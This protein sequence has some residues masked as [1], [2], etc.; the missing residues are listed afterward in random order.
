MGN[1]SFNQYKKDPNTFAMPSEFAKF[2]PGMYVDISY[3][4]GRVINIKSIFMT[5]YYRAIDS[6]GKI[7]TLAYTYMGVTPEVYSIN[8]FTLTPDELLLQNIEESNANGKAVYVQAPIGYMPVINFPTQNIIDRYEQEMIGNEKIQNILNALSFTI[9]AVVDEDA[10]LSPP[11][12]LLFIRKSQVKEF[13]EEKKLPDQIGTVYAT[14]NKS[15]KVYDF[16]NI[17]S[18]IRQIMDSGKPVT[19]DDEEIALIPIDVTSETNSGYYETTTTITN[20]TPYC[21][22]P[23]MVKLDLSGAQIKITY[24]TQQP[25][26]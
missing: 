3:G 23:A 8:H 4:N 13:F 18:Y 2:F 10:A 25:I 20:I 17:G 19:K 5:M 26:E 6:E 1:V 16:G 21:A 15:K 11:K 22:S 9:P 12:Y 7:D 24:T 14:Y